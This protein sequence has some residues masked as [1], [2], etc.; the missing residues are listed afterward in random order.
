MFTLRQLY[1]WIT[2]CFQSLRETLGQHPG[3]NS[4]RN[5]RPSRNVPK[6]C[7][8]DIHVIPLRDTV[9]HHQ[10]RGCWCYP[11]LQDENGYPQYIGDRIPVIVVH[12]ALD[13]RE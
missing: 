5:Q 12:N 3:C 13:G 6:W 8:D 9:E 2:E 4:G 7:L 10:V 11:Q 1:H